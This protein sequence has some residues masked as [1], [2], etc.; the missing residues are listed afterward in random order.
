MTPAGHERAH[1]GRPL[2]RAGPST[3]P[4]SRPGGSALLRTFAARGSPTWCG[5]A[6]LT[7]LDRGPRT[8]IPPESRPQ[9]P[10]RPGRRHPGQRHLP[11]DFNGKP[12]DPGQ[13]LDAVAA[14]VPRMPLARNRPAADPGARRSPVRAAPT[15]RDAKMPVRGSQA[16][17]TYQAVAMITAPVRAR[18]TS[19][20]SGSHLQL[21]FGTHPL[22]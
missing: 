19:S 13:L 8:P 20:P 9:A 2:D 10:R 15:T 16:V 22:L 17:P 3:S 5:H 4:A 21:R 18:R 7:R 6:E 11:A 1:L 12:P 14:R